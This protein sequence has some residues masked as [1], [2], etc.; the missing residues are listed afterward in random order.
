MENGALN[1]GAFEPMSAVHLPRFCT[2]SE[3]SSRTDLRTSDLCANEGFAFHCGYSLSPPP[4]LSEE[5]SG[6]RRRPPQVEQGIQRHPQP[7]NPV[8]QR[9]LRAGQETW[10]GCQKPQASFSFNFCLLFDS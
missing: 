10:A 9:M 8:N 6:A 2:R 7:G 3:E 4:S 5:I 1:P